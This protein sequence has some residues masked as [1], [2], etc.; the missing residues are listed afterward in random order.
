MAVI[1][2]ATTYPAG[3]LNVAGH[4]ANVFSTTAGQGIMSEPNGGLEQ[5]N[6]DATFAVRDEH[7]MSEEAVRASQDGLNVPMDLFSNGFGDS[8][9]DED[10][11]REK[12]YITVAG[13]SHRVY[14]PYNARHVIWQW[15][16]FASVY[17]PA[18]YDVAA[19]YNRDNLI[20]RAYIDGLPV[21]AF[22]R[23]LV[24]S[25]MLFEGL[26]TTNDAL[27]EDYEDSTAMWYDFTKLVRNVQAG[28]HE[29]SVKVY[30]ERNEHSVALVAEGIIPDA[31]DPA[32]TYDY[33]AHNR[34]T[35]GVRN[36]RCVSFA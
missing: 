5:A 3:A 23:P 1:T 9:E 17:H 26:G 10:S 20:I 25:A 35:F 36:V 16:T 18:F 28:Y 27:A 7:V 34:I 31:D 2:P 4:N 13:L 6:L 32:D 29:L 19:G 33:Y 14:F 30:M 21:A 15:S 12:V 22:T 11:T 24:P 8:G